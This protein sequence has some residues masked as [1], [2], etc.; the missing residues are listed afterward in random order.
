MR[1]L[2]LASLVATAVALAQ[3]YPPGGGGAGTG[4]VTSVDASGGVQTTSGAPIVL[5]GTIRGA[6]L[7]NTQ[8]GGTYAILDG[9]R[10]KLVSISFATAQ[11]TS[12]AQAGAG[13][14]FLSGW[15]VDVENTG[16]GT[17]TITPATSTIDGAA[18]IALTA[19]QGVRIVS[20]G[21]NY[22]TQRG[23]VGGSNWNGTIDFG[24]ISDGTCAASTFIATGATV[25]TVVTPR[26]PS[27][28][29][30]GLVGTMIVNAADTI[31]VRLCNFSGAPLDPAL[32]TFAAYTGISGGG[33][34]GGASV[35]IG[36]W[37]SL[38]ASPAA[39]GDTYKCADAPYEYVGTG[40]PLVWQAYYSTHPVT[41][42]V[43]GS[44]TWV[45]Q[46][47]ATIEATHGGFYLYAPADGNLNIKIRDIALPVAPYTLTTAFVP[48]MFSSNFASL[49]LVLRDSVSGGL[50]QF[51]IR[52]SG[53][54]LQLISYK[55]NSPTSYN[56]SYIES[57]YFGQGMP[58]LVSGLMWLKIVDNNTNRIFY[59]SHDGYHWRQFYSVGRTDF[60]TPDFAGVFVDAQNGTYDAGISLVHWNVTS[61]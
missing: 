58:G 16:A 38:P 48:M 26:W 21:T 4:T 19:S 1:K 30:A 39:L 40:S 9:D 22:F 24:S 14:L 12:I 55:F 20:N 27:N 47:A 15:F 51:G 60:I 41:E 45:N 7:V 18:S 54:N 43:S 32:H 34:G 56:S 33:G 50:V 52:S 42:P 53:G 46:G 5:N 49:G 37:A 35:T 29:E 25:T 13:G 61:P 36:P 10:G 6:E 11:A 2:V 57:T 31:A 17:V 3:Y 28:L 59:H 8:T 23:M 44:F